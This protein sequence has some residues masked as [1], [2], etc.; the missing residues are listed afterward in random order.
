[1]RHPAVAGAAVAAVPD[2]VQGDEVFACIVPKDTCTDPAVLARE[3]TQWCLTQLAYYKAPGFIA[4]VEALPLTATQKLQRG[5]LKTLAADL[6]AD[7]AT[8]DLRWLK[9]RTAA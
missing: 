9:K 4:F 3:I 7:P 2:T 1:M 8:Q 5:V 6:L